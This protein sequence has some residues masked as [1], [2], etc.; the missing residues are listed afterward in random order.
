MQR[1]NADPQKTQK[2]K[3]IDTE[4][5][6]FG[7]G[8]MAP[9]MVC[10]SWASEDGAGV[11][12]G[13]DKKTEEKL[14]EW[15]SDTT[16][17]LVGQFIAYDMAVIAAMYPRLLPLIFRA[18]N[19]NRVTDTQ[20]REKLK[21]IALGTIGEKDKF[22]SLKT[23]AAIYNYPVDL[24]KET[25]RTGYSSLDG[26]P[27]HEW[28]TGAVEYARHDAIAT[29]WVHE[30]QEEWASVLKDQFRQTRASFALQLARVWGLVTNPLKVQRLEK[31]LQE[32]L[33]DAKTIL[34]EAGWVYQDKKG[35][36][37]KRAKEVKGWVKGKYPDI[38][39][40]P[41]G[42]VC[43]DA[44]TIAQL[45]DPLLN[46]YSLWGGATTALS[47]AKELDA[48]IIH[49]RWDSLKATG[50]TGSEDP[51]VQNRTTI[52]GDRECIEPREGCVF[53]SLDFP[54]L[55]LRT[56][57]QVL[58]S[59]G[60]KSRLAEVLQDPK[61]DPHS[62]V[63]AGLLHITLEEALRRK[64]DPEDLEFYKAR[65][66]GK[67]ANFGLA[68]G[69]GLGA[70]IAQARAQYG[71]VIDYQEAGLI[72]KTWL[73]T[74]PEFGEYFEWVKTQT[75]GGKG[76]VLQLYTDRIRGNVPFTVYANSLFQGLGADVAKAALWAIQEVCYNPEKK[77]PLFGSR[78]VNFIHDEFLIET[79]KG[80]G[81]TEKAKALETLVEESVAPLLPDVPGMRCS[82]IACTCWS[83]KA[84]RV[85]VDNQLQVWDGVISKG[86]ARCTVEKCKNR[87]AFVHYLDAKDLRSWGQFRCGTHIETERNKERW[88]RL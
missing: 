4:T 55:E 3:A 86:E 39:T 16:L 65:Q 13:A 78:L 60:I 63:A 59:L 9:K 64:E 70:F 69:M 7:P 38:K 19:Q 56:V 40:T 33:E 20:I 21:R 42:E 37:H 34:V 17:L 47:R 88:V 80:P 74:W 50:R 82:A 61:G 15:L 10:L 67:I 35:G 1:T 25:W 32:E 29:L 83:K 72:R 30:S 26:V 43:L 54:G 68:G 14:E 44:D 53:L 48:D 18:Y 41:T 77:H 49:T 76:T 66:T 2:T 36:W 11:A 73:Q 5:H 6:L 8:C 24:D 23:L 84:K 71:V 75:K 81:L 46:A 22:I 87:A 45:N 52:P 62:I 51:N 79:P 31:L 57:S 12:L 85:V 58:V 27:L 28:P